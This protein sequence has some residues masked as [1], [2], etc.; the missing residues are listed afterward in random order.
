[1]RR[2]ILLKYTGDQPNLANGE[3]SGLILSGFL[4]EN[5]EI[6]KGLKQTM[7]GIHILDLL[8]NIDAIGDDLRDVGGIL[9]PSI[10]VK[11]A[12][13]TSRKG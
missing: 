13:I 7:C 8:K 6:T 3:F 11:Q 2:G 1:M 4:I 12:M 10:R 5:G 9:A